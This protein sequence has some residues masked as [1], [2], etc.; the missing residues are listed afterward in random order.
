[1]SKIILYQKNIFLQRNSKKLLYAYVKERYFP[2][3]SGMIEGFVCY[4]LNR[5]KFTEA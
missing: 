1:M 3:D 4:V 2:R 5:F